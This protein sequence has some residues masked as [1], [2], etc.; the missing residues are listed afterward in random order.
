[1]SA[2]LVKAAGTLFN[3]VAVSGSTT[4]N[5]AVIDLRGGSGFNATILW[6]GTPSGL[7]TVYVCNDYVPGRT[8][9]TSGSWA[10]L[11]I[12]EMAAKSPAGAAGNLSI[13]VETRA[14][15]AYVAYV[16]SASTGTVSGTA[17]VG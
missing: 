16:N 13:D 1:M 8:I 10:A 12:P 2:T 17:G 3:A 5:S 11:D 14:L 9:A 6:T 4:Y 7:F 15:F